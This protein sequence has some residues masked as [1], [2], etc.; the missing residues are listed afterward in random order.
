M[1]CPKCNLDIDENIMSCPM[2]QTKLLEQ[3][4]EE[5]SEKEGTVGTALLLT[6]KDEIQANIVE[7][8]LKA[9]GIP[10][11]RKYK[12]NDTFGKIVLGLT[13]NGI[14]LYVPKSAFEEAKGIIEN[15]LPEEQEAE[16]EEALEIE[17]MK[18]KYEDRRRS[19]AWIAIL[20]FVPGILILI[21][22]AIYW[23][24]SLLF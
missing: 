14:D 1:R 22:V 18:E 6:A 20:F 11:S 5:K 13:V 16:F 8:L 12:G 9:Y 21:G 19:R 10:L 23:I 7:S 3:L 15:E 4:Q 2:C 17:A 24:I